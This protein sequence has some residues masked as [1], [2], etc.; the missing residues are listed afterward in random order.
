MKHCKYEQKIKWRSGRK[1]NGT[2]RICIRDGS[3]RNY[4]P[5][6]LCPYFEQT[7]WSKLFARFEW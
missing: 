7:F 2:Q 6:W 1:Y 4:C 5:N 3:V